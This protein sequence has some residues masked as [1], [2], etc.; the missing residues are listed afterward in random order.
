MPPPTPV[1]PRTSLTSLTADGAISA[2]VASRAMPF[3]AVETLSIPDARTGMYAAPSTFTSSEMPA[4][5]RFCTSV[6]SAFIAGYSSWIALAADAAAGAMWA[7][8]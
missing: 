7:M 1:N 5:N 8:S 3:M 4:K 6:C 2:C